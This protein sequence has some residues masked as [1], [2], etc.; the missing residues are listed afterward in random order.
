MTAPL[1]PLLDRFRIQ[2]GILSVLIVLLVIFAMLSPKTFLSPRIY[3]SFASTIPFTAILA[4]ALTLL[5]IGDELD[6][7]FPAVMAI[8]GL[9]F[10]ETYLH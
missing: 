1:P 4:L 8:S 7:S 9:C 2:I 6:L 10:S 3:I 5:V